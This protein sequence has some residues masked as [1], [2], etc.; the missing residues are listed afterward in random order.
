MQKIWRFITSLLFIITL[1]ITGL[2]FFRCAQSIYNSFSTNQYQGYLWL[3]VGMMSFV[4][5]AIIFFKK[6]LDI[7][8]TMTHEG[9][10]MLVGGL[11][12][13]KKIYEF[14]AKSSDTLKQ[15]DNTLGY[16]SSNAQSANIFST[17][18]PYMLPYITFAMVFFRL[19]IKNECLPIIDFI[20]G[21]TLMFHFSCWKKDMRID[22][23]DIQRCGVFRSYLF[24]W[25]FIFFN[26]AIIFYSLGGGMTEPVNILQA[27]V[28]WF[29]KAW[30]DIKW[31]VSLI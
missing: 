17:L 5:I 24:I 13:R 8:Q 22:Q 15:N 26:L 4:L 29:S 9:A 25:T 18:A 2:E 14:N 31:L 11:F 3:C 1:I 7:M 30:T 6:N 23:S 16:V 12:L 19:M 27:N 10:H 21:F 20:I 28:E